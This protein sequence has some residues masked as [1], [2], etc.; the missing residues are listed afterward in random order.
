V[1]GYDFHFE[2]PYGAEVGVKLKVIRLAEG[3]NG[4]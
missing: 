4:K 2:K 1:I 3:G